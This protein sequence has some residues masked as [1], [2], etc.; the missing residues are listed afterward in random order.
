[1]ARV[2]KKK[3]LD[4]DINQEKAAES[5]LSFPDL[6][7]PALSPPLMTMPDPLQYN[8]PLNPADPF[9]Y[10][11]IKDV[12]RMPNGF[13]CSVKFDARDSYL[14]F[15]ACADD[16]EAHGRAIYQA[17]A[18]K[19]QSRVPSYLPTEN[20]LLEATQERIARELRKAGAE[21]TK[22]QDRVD[23]DDASEADIA[24]LRAWKIYRVALNRLPE[25]ENYPHPITWPAAPDAPAL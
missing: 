1:M 15:L 11:D 2:D 24:L 9:S 18:S 5:S 12:V 3:T 23:V 22:Y 17:C 8:E 7:A 21:I 4:S 20:E 10:S 6:A 14:P 16:V 25:Q 13:Q 19:K